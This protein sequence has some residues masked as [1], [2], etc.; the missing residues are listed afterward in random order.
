MSELS[1][2]RHAPSVFASDSLSFPRAMA[3][4]LNPILAA[5]WTPRWPRP[6]KPSTATVSPGSRTAVAESIE[7]RNPGAHQR[8]G[9]SRGQLPGH[10]RQRFLARNRVI[11]IAAIGSDARDVSGSLAGEEIPLAA[12][13]AIAAI[14]SIPAQTHAFAALSIPTTPG[15]TAST[16]VP[17]TS[18]PGTRGYAIPGKQ[19]VFRNGIAVAD[20]ARLNF[21]PY[22]PRSGLG[23]GPLHNLK[24]DPL[25]GRPA[26]RIP[27]IV[28]LLLPITARP[29]LSDWVKMASKNPHENSRFHCC[30]L[31]LCPPAP[32]Q[33]GAQKLATRR[34]PRLSAST[35]IPR[36][37][38][39]VEVTRADAPNGADRFYNMVK[40]K[41]LD[42][43]GF[44]ASSPASWRSSA[45]AGRSRSHESLGCADSGRSRESEQCPGRDDFRANLRAQQPEHPIVYQLRR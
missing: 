38:R 43:A 17:T 6:P 40:A 11:R 12:I 9:I 16:T 10:A 4:V 34:L 31:A 18:C 1:I 36:A 15:P 23:Y 37:A 30:S 14:T 22:H 45:L 35:S 5:Y 41:Y 7:R 32:V 42:G 21:D 8:R 24:C 19:P 28:F 27:G 20:T 29:S 3:T 33:A 39:G 44:F 25:R 13:V 2:Y 26:C